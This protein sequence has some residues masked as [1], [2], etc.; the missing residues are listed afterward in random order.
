MSA[1]TAD[2]AHDHHHGTFITTYIF[3]TDHK[4]I[5]KQF[6]WLSLVMM[7]LGGLCAAF[8]FFKLFKLR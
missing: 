6:L 1:T 5:A 3:S 7:I 4:M 2:V 8:G